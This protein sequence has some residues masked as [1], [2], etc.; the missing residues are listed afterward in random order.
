MEKAKQC[1]PILISGEIIKYRERCF[2]YERFDWPFVLMTLFTKTFGK[3][4]AK[5][6]SQGNQILKRMDA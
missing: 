1:Q 5:I 6:G 3:Q 2:T 4:R